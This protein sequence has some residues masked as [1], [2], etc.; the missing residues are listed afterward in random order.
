MKN[1]RGAAWTAYDIDSLSK[2]ALRGECRSIDMTF[3]GARTKVDMKVD[4][5]TTSIRDSRWT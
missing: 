1:G 5:M 3:G 2:K 4:M